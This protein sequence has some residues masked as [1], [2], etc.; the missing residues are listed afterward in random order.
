MAFIRAYAFKGPGYFIHRAK[1]LA[2]NPCL[3]QFAKLQ[4]ADNLKIFTP[5]QASSTPDKAPLLN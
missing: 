1:L 4:K 3:S 5:I 2:A